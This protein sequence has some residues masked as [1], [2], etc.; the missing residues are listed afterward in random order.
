LADWDP[1]RAREVIRWPLR[2]ALLSYLAHLRKEAMENYRTE[3]LV[4]AVLAPY[5]KRKTEPPRT[6]DVLR[7]S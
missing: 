2:E 5:G 4:W 3:L 1:E 6:P 7:G